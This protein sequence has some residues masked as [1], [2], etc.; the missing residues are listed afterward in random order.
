MQTVSHPPTQPFVD[1]NTPAC[2][3]LKIKLAAAFRI[4]ARRK[5]DDGIAGHIS[6]RVP[7]THDQ[8]WVNPLGLF[9][10][11]VTAS[12]LLVVNLAGD[13]LEGDR[14]YNQ[15]AFA[16]HSTL[17]AERH[18][19]ESICHTHPPKGTAFAALGRPIKLIDQT[20]C[21][22]YEDHTLVEEYDGVVDSIDQAKAMHLAIG[23]HRAAVLQ[24]HGLITLGGTIEQAVVDMLDLERTCE[25]N[26]AVLSRF[27]EVKE[28]GRDAALQARNVFTSPARLFLQWNALVR[29]IE[30][31][32][33]HYAGRYRMSSN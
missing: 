9:F 23:A 1:R 24:N 8:F 17:H 21:S 32:E 27:D 31:T 16:I 2:V 4:I 29:Q 18:H 5:M 12:D 13:I 26:L 10:E 14:P 25:L 33:P 19:V 30:S 3:E 22:F 28:V 6:C 20:A 7:G 15:A 11:E